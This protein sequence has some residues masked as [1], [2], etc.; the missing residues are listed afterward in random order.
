M[1]TKEK[2]AHRRAACP[3]PESCDVI[4]AA[5]WQLDFIPLIPGRG[6]SNTLQHQLELE[7]FG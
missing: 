4:A 5:N 6:S 7:C 1:S 3:S 2:R